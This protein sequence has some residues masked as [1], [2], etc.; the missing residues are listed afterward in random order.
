MKPWNL[1]GLAITLFAL[2]ALAARLDALDC[3]RNG[4]DDLD[5]LI[6]GTSRD[7]NLDGVPD[8]CPAEDEP[9]AFGGGVWLGSV[10]PVKSI[11]DM[12]GDGDLDLVTSFRDFLTPESYQGEF[13]AI[14]VLLNRGDGEIAREE[15]HLLRAPLRSHFEA[16]VDGDGDVDSVA[17]LV[18]DR[19]SVSPRSL[20]VLLNQGDGALVAMND[21]PVAGRAHRPSLNDVD[22][23]G[24]P[25]F[26][27]TDHG[28]YLLSAP[29]TI[30]T[31]LVVIYNQGGGSFG[32]ERR[33]P[34]GDSPDA[35]VMTDL[36]GDGD[37]DAIVSNTGDTREGEGPTVDTVSVLRN[38][39][40]GTFDPPVPHALGYPA[41][42]LKAADL[43]G[44][45][46]G[47][48]LAMSWSQP[49]YS[50]LRGD[51]HGGFDAVEHHPLPEG[52]GPSLV[53]LGD[54][55]GDGDLD[56][57]A[58]RWGHDDANWVSVRINRGSATFGEP[59][60]FAYAE[61]QPIDSI[62]ADLDGDGDLDIATALY[63]RNR[64]GIHW[65][66]GAG[67]FSDRVDVQLWDPT[68]SRNNP[69]RV[70]AADMD[71]DGAIDIVAAHCIVFGGDPRIARGEPEAGGCREFLRGDFN[72][73]GQVSLS[74][75]IAVRRWL[76]NG[77]QGP[78]CMDAADA[79]DSE[80]IDMGD[81]VSIVVKLLKS[82]W[83]ERLPDP[84]LEP[85]SDPTYLGIYPT[86]PPEGCRSYDVV[87][88]SQ[89]NASITF[90][91]VTGAPG[92]EV[93]IPVLLTS[94]VPV[95]GFQLV[96]EYDPARLGIVS[97]ELWTTG[98]SFEGT[99]Y[100]ADFAISGE[101]HPIPKLHGLS[102]HPE[103]GAFTVLVF[104][105][106]SIPPGLDILVAKI[107]AVVPETAEAD[108]VVSLEPAPGSDGEGVGPYRLRNEITVESEARF[109]SAFSSVGVARVSIVGDQ[110]FFRGDS[111][112]D[113][114]VNIT[115]AISLLG[116][117][118]LG[119]E[120]PRCADAADANDDGR[121]DI[122]DGL[123]ILNFLFS[124]AA[125]LPPPH[126]DR[127]LDPTPDGLRCRGPAA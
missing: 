87:P 111:N 28:V 107:R 76:Y 115:D 24:D 127:G 78:S 54:A 6:A 95:E 7:C 34:A 16:D 104:G 83:L 125:G 53:H 79:N 15:R 122:A 18:E 68:M 89:G 74:D 60:V 116:A 88:P 41:T 65:N 3:N 121:V 73:D 47:D 39:G 17:L 69:E 66:G 113:A 99:Y 75:A 90:G 94:D 26:V 86:R 48:I 80:T 27:S 21:V 119:G 124:G 98:L 42:L 81:L 118:F 109:V 46:D 56:L 59:Q 61:E 117:L 110:A 64:V 36:D 38:R 62:L 112:G 72:A 97:G 108:T 55:D 91:A 2:L 114:A 37:L 9:G 30:G 19:Y 100:E 40:D 44:D 123:T 58:S 82:D 105:R 32:D 22:G 71:G 25:D 49:R 63:D 13:D 45:G 92:E 52:V 14:V 96:M 50:V 35:H 29:D 20:R 126:P 12:D 102:I 106:S 10:Q 33:F 93:E 77:A 4:S 85:G 1:V 67:V 31:D 84:L 8:E 11:A 5:D 70:S 101:D 120:R 103:A 23:D 51:G 43:D 57:A